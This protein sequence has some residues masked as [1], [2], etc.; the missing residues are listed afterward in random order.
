MN[1]FMPNDIR[2]IS[3]NE[4]NED[5]HPRFSCRAKTYRYII[6]TD[7]Q[8]DVFDRNYEWQI[9]KELDELYECWEALSVDE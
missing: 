4:E 3:S 1:N 6:N 8:P 9:K 7:E 5:F 2:I